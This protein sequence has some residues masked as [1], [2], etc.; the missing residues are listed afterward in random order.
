MGAA[1]P[2]RAGGVVTADDGA[3]T[4]PGWAVE[5]L[6]D[7]IA[8]TEDPDATVRHAAMIRVVGYL[9][10]LLNPAADDTQEV[11]Q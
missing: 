5:H 11:A 1:H 3:V 9:D 8:R 2:S 7:L 10:G 4:L 6:R